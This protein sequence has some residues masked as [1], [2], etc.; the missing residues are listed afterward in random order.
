[1]TKHMKSTV[2]FL[3][4]FTVNLS[5][6]QKCGD[7][8]AGIQNRSKTAQESKTMGVFQFKMVADK[9][10]FVLDSSWTFEISDAWVE[11]TWKYKCVNSQPVI[12]KESSFQLVVEPK[13]HQIKPRFDYILSKE[14]TGGTFLS[15]KPPIEFKYQ[16]EDTIVL[17]LKKFNR[18]LIDTTTALIARITF[19][20]V[21][22]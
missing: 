11:N 3:V 10:T 13:T 14:G 16:G 2:V 22:R 17:L 12:D 1:M 7:K 4:L 5:K 6:A 9:K 15:S 19:I 18:P 8:I 21:N 20:K